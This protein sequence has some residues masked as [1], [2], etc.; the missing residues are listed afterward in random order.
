MHLKRLLPVSRAAFA[1][2][3]LV[4]T[5]LAARADVNAAPPAYPDKVHVSNGCHVS[6]LTYLTKFA[7]QFP[8]EKGE[9]LIIRMLNADGVRRLHTISLITWRGQLWCRDEYFGVFPLDCPVAA[10]PDPEGLVRLARE[11][12]EGQAQLLIRTAGVTL[13]PAPPAKMSPAQR[14]AE[15]AVVAGLV[16]LAITYQ[17]R[18]GNREFPLV[19]FHPARGQVAVYD[20][21][22]GTCVGECMVSNDD[23]FVS[24]VATKLGYRVDTVCVDPTALFE[25]QIAANTPVTGGAR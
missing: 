13:R 22:H 10:R 20:P 3:I 14:S 7:A 1:L 24:A 21:Q 16:P 25:I 17:V 12:L 15:T 23:Q 11:A 5:A 4:V 2:A 18:S 19:F 9:P 6:T 8:A